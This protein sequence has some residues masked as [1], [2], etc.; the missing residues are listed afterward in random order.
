MSIDQYQRNSLTVEYR[1]QIILDCLL[2]VTH[3]GGAENLL[4]QTEYGIFIFHFN[5]V[6]FHQRT[7]VE[8]LGKNVV[9]NWVQHWHT[10]SLKFCY[11]IFAL[12]F[13]PFVDCKDELIAFT[14]VFY[15]NGNYIS[16]STNVK[17]LLKKLSKFLVFRY[18][19]NDNWALTLD[20]FAEW[21]RLVYDEHDLLAI[22]F[23]C[24]Y[25]PIN[26][27]KNKASFNV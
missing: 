21:V 6:L 20:D 8:T 11:K 14:V 10:F 12:V 3:A 9:K 27:K 4:D 16:D 1:A 7:V 2:E 22:Y 15:W 13:S 25:I 26:F 24:Q 18:V 5:S 23:R 19:I 17:L